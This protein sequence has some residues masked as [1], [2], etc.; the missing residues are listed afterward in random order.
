MYQQGFF[1]YR[2]AERRRTAEFGPTG[3]MYFSAVPAFG[4]VL[5]FAQR[6]LQI[7]NKIFVILNANT[8]SHQ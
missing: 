2:G 8:Q 7:S 6:L 3:Q 1:W 4:S 5:Y